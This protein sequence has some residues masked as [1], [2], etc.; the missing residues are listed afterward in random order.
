[1]EKVR[2]LAEVWTG[3]RFRPCTNTARYDYR[4]DGRPAMCG[5]HRRRCRWV[6]PRTRR[7][8][9]KLSSPFGSDPLDLCHEHML[10]EIDSGASVLDGEINAEFDMGAWR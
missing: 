9:R 1:M 4:P 5:V 7:L 3:Y 6:N 10:A 8:C 2:C